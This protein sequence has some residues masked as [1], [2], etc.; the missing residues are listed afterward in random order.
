MNRV[1]PFAIRK[2]LVV[3]RNQI[4]ILDNDN[5][6]FCVD[7]SHLILN[8]DNDNWLDFLPSF[9]VNLTCVHLIT[10]LKT[11]LAK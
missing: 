3:H 6:V 5:W 2:T 4:F 10:L 9:A 7:P 11:K 1:T 8:N